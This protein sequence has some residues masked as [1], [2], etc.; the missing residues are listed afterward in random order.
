MEKKCTNGSL[1]RIIIIK[2]KRKKR[3]TDEKKKYEIK[4]LLSHLHSKTRATIRVKTTTTTT[5]ATIAG[6]ADSSVLPLCSSVAVRIR[7]R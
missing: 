1:T 5:T 6:T 7:K 4:R 3:L 2:I